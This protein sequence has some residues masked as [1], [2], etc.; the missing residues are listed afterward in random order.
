MTWVCKKHGT[1]CKA[2]SRGIAE[3]LNRIGMT[4]GFLDCV[5]WVEEK[6]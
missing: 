4:P 5:E 1:N 3:D 6:K 2:Y